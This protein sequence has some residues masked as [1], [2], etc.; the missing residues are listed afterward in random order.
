[1]SK[2]NFSR[3]TKGNIGKLEEKKDISER[4]LSEML[5]EDF[6]PYFIQDEEKTVSL[7]V[8]QLDCFRINSEESHVIWSPTHQ[9]I[10]FIA[11]GTVK[12]VR[13]KKSMKIDTTYVLVKGKAGEQRRGQDTL[14][15]DPEST[16]LNSKQNEQLGQYGFLWSVSEKKDNNA[17]PSIYE[18]VMGL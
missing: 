11:D 17:N 14:R 7:P 10:I 2:R 12:F 16:N 15:A 4:S 18:V 13:E 9:A 5:S 1:M 6:T 8:N 3:R